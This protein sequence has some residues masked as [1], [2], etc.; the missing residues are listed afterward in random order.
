MADHAGATADRTFRDAAGMRVGERLVK[1][2]AGH[3][4][5]VDVVQDAIP[6]LADDRQRPG[7]AH[8]ALAPLDGAQ[9]V[10][11]HA[12]AVRV[13]DRDLAR[14]ETRLADP[15]EPGQLAVAVQAMRPGE[16]GVGPGRPG[17][18][19]DHRHSRAHRAD[20]D[21]ERPIAADHGRVT[22]ADALDVR[23]RVVVLGVPCPTTMPSSRARMRPPSMR[24]RC[25]TLSAQ[26]I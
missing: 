6:R 17:S 21:L 22:D 3:V 13:R 25:E 26:V 23:D 7:L 20:P 11:H 19:P 12:D 18:W 10:A 15:R 24:P 8:A 2:I 4:L 9:R 5:T 1:V 16:R 14:Q